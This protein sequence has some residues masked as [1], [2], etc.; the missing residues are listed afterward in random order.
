M[1]LERNYLL[2]GVT[3]G[4]LTLTIFCLLLFWTGYLTKLLYMYFVMPRIFLSSDLVIS[5][6]SL[7]PEYEEEPNEGHSYAFMHLRGDI[8]H[9]HFNIAPDLNYALG[10]KD[11]QWPRKE[12][13]F[14]RE[15]EG[16]GAPKIIYFD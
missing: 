10:E 4:I 15:R 12:N 7:I 13:I 5:T 3:V 11:W 6:E 8:R 2:R 1:S 16:S 9:A 14:Y